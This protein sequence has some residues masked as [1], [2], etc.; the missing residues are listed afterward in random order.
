M[1]KAISVGMGPIGLMIYIWRH[2]PHILLLLTGAKSRELRL[3]HQAEAVHIQQRRDDHESEAQGPQRVAV[4]GRGRFLG[5]SV[6]VRLFLQHIRHG[7]QKGRHELKKD[8]NRIS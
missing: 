3:V 7:R 1:S 8:A 6:R 2:G 4:D 5:R